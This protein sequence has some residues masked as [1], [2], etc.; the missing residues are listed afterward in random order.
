MRCNMKT[1]ETPLCS[2]KHAKLSAVRIFLIIFIRWC[3][4]IKRKKCCR[5][6]ITYEQNKVRTKTKIF[7][8][9]LQKKSPAPAVFFFFSHFIA[10]RACNAVKLWGHAQCYDMRIRLA[11]SQDNILAVIRQPYLSE[12]LTKHLDVVFYFFF[13]SAT[14]PYATSHHAYLKASKNLPGHK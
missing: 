6:D 2:L 7:W 14:H 1:F 4:I 13:L 9:A 3:A 11:E 10:I 12:N 5:Q 8:C